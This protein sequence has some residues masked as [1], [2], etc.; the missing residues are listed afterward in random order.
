MQA[1]VGVRELKANLSRYLARVKEGGESLVITEHGKPVARLQP[2][3]AEEDLDATMKRLQA[4]GIISW[5]GQKPGPVPD[6]PVNESA[7]LLSDIV[8]ELRDFLAYLSQKV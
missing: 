7:V 8:S 4:L 2:L 1:T 3:E 5:N 6:R